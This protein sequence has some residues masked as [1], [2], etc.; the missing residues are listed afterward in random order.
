MPE[1]ESAVCDLDTF[2]CSDVWD[3]LCASTALG[4]SACVN[5]LNGS[6]YSFLSGSVYV[7]YDCDGIID[8]SDFGLFEVEMQNFGSGLGYMTFP[9]GGYELPLPINTEYS[10]APENYPGLNPATSHLVT[11]TDQSQS[12]DGVNFGL[13]PIPDYYDLRVVV[14][15]MIGWNANT[16]WAAGAERSLLLKVQNEGPYF[17][18]GQLVIEFPDQAL[19]LIQ[20]GGGIADSG[21][22]ILDLDPINPYGDD[23]TSLTFLLNEDAPFTDVY[24]INVEVVI[25]DDLPQ[26]QSPSNNELSLEFM[27]GDADGAVPYCNYIQPD[28]GFPSDIAC[29]QAICGFDEFCCS[30]SWD[31]ICASLVLDEPECVNCIHGGTNIAVEGDVYL[32]INCNEVYDAED[33]LV[34][35]AN[36]FRNGDL[37]TTTNS[38]GSYTFIAPMWDEVTVSTENFYGYQVN[39]VQLSIQDSSVAGIDFALCA[40]GEVVNLG[41]YISQVGLPPRPGFDLEYEVC[42]QNLGNSNTGG[43]ITFDFAGMQGI[44]LLD[45]GDGIVDGTE[46]TFNVEDIGVF[47]TVCFPITFNVPQGTSAGT[48]L[49]AEATV[50][51]MSELIVDQ[52][53]H[54][55]YHNNISEVVAAYDPNDKTVNKPVVN[56]TEIEDGEGVELEYVIRFQNTG[57]FFATFVRVEDVLPDLLDLNT[58]EMI[59]ASHDYELIVH[60]DQHIEWYF[61]NIMLPDSTTDEPGSHG[62][63]HFSINTVPGVQLEDVIEN[64]ASIFFDFKEPVITEPA[65]TT[66]IDCSEGSLSVLG[67]ETVCPGEQL[68]LTTNRPEFDI[69][70]STESATVSGAEYYLI[71]PD[72]PIE[73]TVEA[74]HPV[75]TLT[76]TVIIPVAEVPET[77][78]F[79]EDNQLVA[80]AG[81][82][83]TWYLD[84]E[85]IDWATEQ[86]IVPFENGT[87]SVEVEYDNGCVGTGEIL[88]QSVGID[89]LNQSDILLV[90]N[91]AIDITQLVLPDGNW[92]VSM[93]D[94]SGKVIFSEEQVTVNRFDISLDHLAPGLYFVSVQS[95]DNRM[96]RKLVVE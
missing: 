17:T 40:E 37:A 84:G 6:Q 24:S 23:F 31:G 61:D 79:V 27:V 15:S 20:D 73:I 89:D 72:E 30:A 57:N 3:A 70:W 77:E 34:P 91:P 64:S 74:S 9:D 16:P 35:N 65:F 44:T 81:E 83:Y 2:C 62:Q 14:A 38:N 28:G 25:D 78:I 59:H 76:T 49:T 39:P 68:V 33:V 36:I 86:W 42:V 13:C 96:V 87:Y 67:L 52:Y 22:I 51:T 82:S 50:E 90:P 21:E 19:Q 5:C 85:V 7:D 95:Q 93:T 88:F 48:M 63:I 41:V 55:N 80:T 29:E 69:L 75:C 26:D 11:T 66:F 60:N 43:I 4:E 8:A 45:A 54:D 10:I 94:V 32:D 92:Q 53:M 58:L 46:I 71:A 47:E 56:H 12:W 1:C 18:G